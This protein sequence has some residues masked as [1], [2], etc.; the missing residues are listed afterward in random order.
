MRF[1]DLK[2]LD[3]A[4]ASYDKAIA[5]KPDYAEAYN[6]RGNALKDLK[7]LD[8]AL[9]SYD[10]AIALKPDYAEAY[11][12]RGNALR[13]LKRL[14]EALASYDKAIALKPDYAEAYNNRGNALKDLKRLDEALVSYDKALSL[15]PDLVGA[16][17][18]RLHAKMHLCDWINFDTECAHL[19]SSVKN[20]KA[21]T[22]PFVFLGI[23][24]SPDD[25]LQCAKLWVA[26]KYP[27]SKR[28]IWQGEQ[29]RHDRI[30]V[31]YVSADFREHPVSYL[32]AGMFECHDKSRFELQLFHLDLTISRNAAAAKGVI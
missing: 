25:Q 13:D 3:E 29:Y 6:N 20:R 7:R 23:S 12:N 8:E 31:A 27:P 18:A 30:R 24:S 15:E 14:D 21:N 26:E 17:G 32:I 1:K 28:S 16:E 4:L 9:A 2:R 5:L 19:I 10:K 11:N 22:P